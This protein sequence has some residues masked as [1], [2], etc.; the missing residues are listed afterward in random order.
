M[1]WQ[2]TTDVVNVLANLGVL[3]C[4]WVYLGCTWGVL[5]VYL[6]CTQRVGS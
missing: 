6:G 1:C 3:G 5:R 4:T 2:C